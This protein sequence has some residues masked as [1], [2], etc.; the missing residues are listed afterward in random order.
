[1][2]KAQ[3]IIKYASIVSRETVRIALMIAALDDLEVKLGNILNAYV[4]APVTEKV[5]TTLGPEFGN[6]ARKTAVIVKA[7]YGLKLAGA[8][9]RSHLARCMESLE[10]ESCKSD[11]DLW[12]TP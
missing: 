1:M 3:A 11:S 9:F 7:L 5:W 8:A 12:L 2:T 4:Q 6:D 10:Y